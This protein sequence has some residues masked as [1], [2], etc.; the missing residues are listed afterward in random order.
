M[1]TTWQ[2]ANFKSI[3]DLKNIKFAPLTILAG[4]NS[5]GKS[6]LIQSILLIVQTMINSDR[7]R[8][9]VLNG[10]F[11]RLGLF[12]DILSNQSNNSRIKIGFTYKPFSTAEDHLPFFLYYGLVL[13]EVN[14]VIVFGENKSKLRN[15]FSDFQIRLISTDINCVTG[16]NRRGARWK[17]LR[18]LGNN[19]ESKIS[20]KF[21]ETGGKPDNQVVIDDKSQNM[22]NSI[23]ELA[24]AEPTKCECE[25]FLPEYI[26]WKSD[27][28]QHL[29]M[30]IC[31]SFGIPI[32]KSKVP[33]HI[34]RNKWPIS[35]TEI[36]PESTIKLLNSKLRPIGR[37]ILSSIHS[38]TKLVNQGNKGIKFHDIEMK[39]RKLSDSVSKQ[40][41]R[42]S[43][44]I[45]KDEMFFNKLVE[46]LKEVNLDPDNYTERRLPP[47]IET[48]SMYLSH[49]L[50]NNIKYLGPLRDEP[51]PVHPIPTGTLYPTDVGLHGEYT[52]AVLDSYKSQ[53][54]HYL[55]SH[56]FE[57]QN[58]T[59][60][61]EEEVKLEKAI[62]DWVNYL[63]VA[64]SVE[65]Q[66]IGK[67]GTQLTI[68]SPGEATPHDLM[69][70]G[71]GV[72]QILPILVMC[73]LAKKGETLIFE[74][75]ELHLHPKVQQRLGDFF[76]SMALLGKQC[77][78]ETHSE[79]IINRLRRRIA[80]QQDNVLHDK[81]KLYF[82]SK[83]GDQTIFRDV[84]INE[85]G[86]ILEWPEGFFDQSQKESQEI[87]TAALGKDTTKHNSKG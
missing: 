74:Q 72:S 33:A 22:A 24:P 81:I 65:T 83:P 15:D 19:I 69:H 8:P 68:K 58:L 34:G 61:H 84:E 35:T 25:H 18:G 46:S 42:E 79:Y 51:K 39:F 31:D 54:I 23:L 2:L 29:A 6:T 77:I 59:T 66:D 3:K 80:I 20:I 32:G 49:F 67:L 50:S 17:W 10:V 16:P 55:S 26:I 28:Y 30:D 52:A 57:P 75:P 38:K 87:L 41:E 64:E 56:V 4:P 73:L 53:P 45:S 5:S 70:V 85:Y 36:V 13:K 78:I 40:L 11:T 48:T 44:N 21:K 1:I 63:G 82:V 86:A 71:I 9:L 27:I 60:A 47:T 14:C 62:S 37:D 12:N 7:Y 76:L 43:N